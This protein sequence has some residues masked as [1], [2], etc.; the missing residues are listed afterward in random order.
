MYT[1]AR[2]VF[3][4]S[5]FL[6]FFLFF[7][8]NS[9]LT[10][11]AAAVCCDERRWGEG[12]R[13]GWEEEEEFCCLS[14]F[15]SFHAIDGASGRLLLDGWGAADNKEWI[16]AVKAEHFFSDSVFNYKKRQTQKGDKWRR[17]RQTNKQTERKKGIWNDAGEPD[18]IHLSILN[19]SIL[20]LPVSLESIFNLFFTFL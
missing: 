18:T 1:R 10:R 6:S 20:V 15:P 9:L 5:F 7:S 2:T 3:G 8:L 12:R 11:W 19:L 17:E 14:P 16:S 4:L 13:D